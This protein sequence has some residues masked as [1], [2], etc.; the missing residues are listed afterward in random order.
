VDNV[1]IVGGGFSAFL[2]K[3]MLGNRALIIKGPLPANYKNFQLKRHST[4]EV[5]K[6]FGGKAYSATK[7]KP[8]FNNLR[9]HDRLVNGGNSKIWGGMIDTSKVPKKIIQALNEYGV[10]LQQLSFDKT[11]SISNNPNLAQL[12]NSSGKVLDVGEYFQMNESSFLESF[13]IEEGRIG[14]K[15]ISCKNN[16]PKIIYTKHLIL[17]TGVVQTIDLLYRSGYL[18]EEDKINLSE[19]GHQRSL[20]L[21]L[22]P[23]LIKKDE[24]ATTVR[25]DMAR[26]FCH[27]LGIQKRLWLSD[28][29]RYTPIFVDQKFTNSKSKYH[30]KI[31]N[32][33]LLELQ[34]NLCGA[35]R[36]KHA[37]GRSIHYCN[38]KINEININQY[39]KEISNKLSGIGMAFVDQNTPG[40][41]SGDIALDAY[42][43][44]KLLLRD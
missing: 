12:L 39:L 1:T 3:L 43:K 40:P 24:N 11:G 44:I 37:H 20:T 16:Q 5:N 25:F 13:F 2:A 41:I 6:F 28:I 18:K 14:L 34:D 35:E 29:S 30:L 27:F 4:L 22:S 19:F 10:T 21:T 36:I 15:V 23:G 32:G 17:C 38:L 31:I 7:L 42:N 8:L 26:A 9:L 33:Y